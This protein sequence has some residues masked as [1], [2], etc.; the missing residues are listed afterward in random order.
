MLSSITAAVG[1][2]LELG[3]FEVTICLFQSKVEIEMIN[4]LILL[5]KKNVINYLI[6]LE[7]LAHT[8]ELKNV[9]LF[10]I[11]G[12]DAVTYYKDISVLLEKYRLRAE[13]FQICT[14]DWNEGNVTE[15]C[16]FQIQNILPNCINKIIYLNA[17][18]L[19]KGE[20]TD[21]WNLDM[22]TSFYAACEDRWISR[23]V[24][25]DEIES[26]HISEK[27]IYYNADVLI[28]NL[29]AIRACHLGKNQMG[30]KINNGEIEAHGLKKF[31]NKY[32]A[33]KI[34]EIKDKKYNEQIMSYRVKDR[35]VK[36][37]EARI[38][39]YDNIDFFS[40]N[41]K[42]TYL[43]M[44][45]LWWDYAS[46]QDAFKKKAKYIK[47]EERRE[48]KRKYLGSKIIFNMNYLRFAF[49]KIFYRDLDTQS[50]YTM[51]YLNKSDLWN[52]FFLLERKGHIYIKKY[53]EMM[54]GYRQVQVHKMCGGGAAMFFLTI[55]C[56]NILNENKDGVLHI[57]IPNTMFA[58]SAIDN[59]DFYV[60]NEYVL[61]YLEDA[62][63]PRREEIEFL[64]YIL[65]R[66]FYHLDFS[67]FLDFSPVRYEDLGGNYE[68][69]NKMR[70]IKF[71]QGEKDRGELY[72]QQ[73]GL[74]GEFVCIAPRNNEYK[75]VYLKTVGA[76]D[77]LS[78]RN[79]TIE[80]YLKA[81]E[82][83]QSAGLGIVHMGRVNRKSFPPQYNIINFSLEYD[84]FLDLY[85]FSRCKF[86]IGDGSGLMN[87]ADMFSRP[88]IQ[89]NWELL[90]S[91]KEI[92]GCIQERK[93]IILPVKYWNEKEKRYLSLKEQLSLEAHYKE[94]RFEEEILKMGY[95]AI[96]NS[97]E[98]IEAA[99][100]EMIECIL[101]NKEYTEE[102][103]C[104]QNI[105]K[106]LI[107][108]SAKKYHMRYP[109]CNIA[110]GFLK[111]NRW[112]L[113]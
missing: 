81:V 97:A 65:S 74:K 32:M 73:H 93:D 23:G 54:K 99:T 105:S 90:T 68:G 6:L 85:L 27:D 86:V 37:S 4:I 53:K 83:I 47:R 80:S 103:V 111:Q 78:H 77:Y 13:Y 50:L 58:D 107:C 36:F 89:A 64:K 39:N 61:K 14:D 43:K 24:D 96:S 104:L 100:N 12:A 94:K 31:L 82:R 109:R 91:S 79:G 70:I 1:V 38:V 75:K 69:L 101:G 30:S 45:D 2:P 95:S 15:S 16:I 49:H 33:F 18:L 106:N 29:F 72:L 3:T 28:I 5:N 67:H 55:I 7:S 48:E 76:N 26:V 84:E 35:D 52:P 44:Y 63:I 112:Y 40:V 25:A 51:E 22:G 17:N 66:Y 57:L 88:T 71:S 21:L 11:G 113:D 19:I 20:L 87:I 108:E 110:I 102:E 46:L 42:D 59:P 98:E 62:Y 60:H 92:M 34:M 10:I 41:K 8:N 56:Y 9:T